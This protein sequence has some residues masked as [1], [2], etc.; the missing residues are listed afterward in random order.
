[1]RY[2]KNE[3]EVNKIT[4]RLKKT[5]NANPATGNNTLSVLKKATNPITKPDKYGKT[6]TGA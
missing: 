4:E 6:G 1:M 5:L 2:R 3:M